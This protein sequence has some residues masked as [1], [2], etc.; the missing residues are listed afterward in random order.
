MSIK[1]YMNKENVVYSHGELF[2][3]N[4][5]VNPDICDMMNLEIFTLSEISQS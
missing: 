4:K 3:H 5:K 1:K 2:I